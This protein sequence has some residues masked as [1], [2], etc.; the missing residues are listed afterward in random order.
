MSLPPE[1]RII[2]CS[3][4]FKGATSDFKIFTKHLQDKL[5]E[6]EAVLGDKGYIGSDKVFYFTFIL[7]FL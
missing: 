5:G 3:P 1:Q 6:F 2:W 7:F 4:A